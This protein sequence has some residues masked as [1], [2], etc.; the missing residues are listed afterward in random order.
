ML[1]GA[2][3]S[4]CASSVKKLIPG[5][6]T[7][8]DVIG[9]GPKQIQLITTGTEILSK[10][11]ERV[12][13]ALVEPSTGSR[14]LNVS[15]DMW[16]AQTRTAPALGPFPYTYHGDGLGEKGIFETNIDFPSDGQWLA[17][18]TVA[19]PKPEFAAATI[20]VGRQI[21]QGVPPQPIVGERAIDVPTPTFANHLGVNPICTRVPM[22]SMHA[23]SLDAA[24][25]NGKPTVLIIATP[26]F[27]Q[28]QLCGPE[29][30][31]V[32]AASKT[33]GDRANFIHVEVYKDNKPATIQKQILSPAANAWHTSA[34]PAIYFIDTAGLIKERSL[35]PLDRADVTTFV[36]KLLA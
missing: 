12:A 29:T 5:K 11:E 20:Q 2:I 8:D 1:L 13:F 4:A 15:G 23:I 33:Y 28:S 16:V 17:V 19:G 9:A 31:L 34:E 22:C 36:E 7:L 24:L 25:K 14:V 6:A 26:A 30:D 18:A 21:Q 35:G 32:M 10:Q 27:C 3:A